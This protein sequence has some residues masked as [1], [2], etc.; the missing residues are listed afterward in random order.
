MT[1]EHS[2]EKE[3]ETFSLK[4]QYVLNGAMFL[5]LLISIFFYGFYVLA[6]FGVSLLVALFFEWLFSKYRKKPLDKD[7]LTTPLLITLMMPL[8]TPFWHS[9]YVVGIATMFGVV[10]GKLMFGGTGKYIFHPAV[11]GVLFATVSFPIQMN[12]I[13]VDQPIRDF[14]F[15]LN[16]LLFG[17]MLGYIGETFRIAIIALGILLFAFKI[18]DWKVPVIFLLTV[19]ALTTLGS[20]LLNISNQDPVTSLL[21]GSLLFGSVFLITDPHLLPKYEQ[22]KVLFAI[23]LGLL[24]ILIRF[25]GTF[26]EGIIFAIILMN[27]ISPL[28]DHYVEEKMKKKIEVAS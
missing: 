28:I 14:N 7:L 3:L 27:T 5:L 25:F 24:T 4:K 19:L 15:P 12:S 13:W 10:F 8:V 1:K 9:L 16:D 18:I 23:G 17:S 22:S 21:F 6:M 11:V 20:S 2:S 26:P